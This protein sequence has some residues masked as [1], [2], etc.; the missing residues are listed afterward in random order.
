MAIF[1]EIF[2]LKFIRNIASVNVKFTDFFIFLFL[3]DLDSYYLEFEEILD[4]LINIVGGIVIRKQRFEF[5]KHL[6]L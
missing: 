5:I 4:E 6:L 2:F 1:K 3:F